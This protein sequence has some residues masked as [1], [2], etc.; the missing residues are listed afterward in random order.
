M[1][2]TNESNM[3]TILWIAAA[4]GIVAVLAI[5]MGMS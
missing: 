5:Y 2:T 1:Q 4:L 3:S